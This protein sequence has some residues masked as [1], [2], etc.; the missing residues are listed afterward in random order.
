MTQFGAFV[1]IG[2]HQDGL[3]HISK[4]TEMFIKNPSKVVKVRQK[5]KFKGYLSG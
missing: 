4:I 1:N 2:V 3:L 5:N